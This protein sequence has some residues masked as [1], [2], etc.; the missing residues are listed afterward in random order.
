[1]TFIFLYKTSICEIIKVEVNIGVTVY[2][3]S[4]LQLRRRLLWFSLNTSYFSFI[5][6]IRNL[7]ETKFN[8]KLLK[9]VDSVLPKC[10]VQDW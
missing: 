8:L 5:K 2:L 3:S 9:T 6:I 4:L 10:G 7:N 1:M